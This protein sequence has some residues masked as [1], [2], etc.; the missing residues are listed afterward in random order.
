[1]DLGWVGPGRALRPYPQRPGAHNTTIQ[2]HAVCAR[3]GIEVRTSTHRCGSI[4]GLSPRR[5]PNCPAWRSHSA[6]LSAQRA[7]LTMRAHS[8][9]KA[10]GEHSWPC[11]L[12]GA[13]ALH[14]P[15]AGRPLRH[16]ANVYMTGACCM[17]G[18]RCIVHVVCCMPGVRCMTGV[19]PNS[20][21]WRSVHCGVW[22]T[23]RSAG[24][25]LDRKP[26]TRP[27]ASVSLCP[28]RLH[29]LRIT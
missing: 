10:A 1:M 25:Y 2:R 3:Q 20:A 23:A 13:T 28:S 11:G 18:V 8:C 27:Q 26:A 15:A 4:I 17:K 12:T 5:R 22:L 6:T 21:Q 29:E 9:A 14:R 24:K 19:P 16:Q 7:Q